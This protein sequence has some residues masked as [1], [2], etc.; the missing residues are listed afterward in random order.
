M[1]NRVPLNP[2]KKIAD[3]SSMVDGKNGVADPEPVAGIMDNLNLERMSNPLHYG[4]VSY[5]LQ[6]TGACS[7]CFVSSFSNPS[8]SHSSTLFHNLG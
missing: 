3:D 7:N 1:A 6:M 5:I 4:E 2:E 8:P